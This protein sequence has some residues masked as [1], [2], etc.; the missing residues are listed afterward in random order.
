M[1]RFGLVVYWALN[2]G[3]I[4]AEARWHVLYRLTIWDLSALKSLAPVLGKL[5]HL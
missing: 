1:L 3:L 2:A 4:V 5:F